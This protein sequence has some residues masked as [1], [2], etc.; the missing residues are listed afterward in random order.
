MSLRRL[1]DARRRLGDAKTL[2]AMDSRDYSSRYGGEDTWRRG[3]VE[4][5]ITN[6]Q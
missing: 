4:T 1:G 6:A 5:K 2:K 3:Y